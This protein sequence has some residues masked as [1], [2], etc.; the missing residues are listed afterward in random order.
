MRKT[1]LLL[2]LWVCSMTA[3]AQKG[4]CGVNAKWVLDEN[5]TLTINGEGEMYD[6]SPHEASWDLY[7]ERIK[8]VVVNGVSNVGSNAF[9]EYPNIVSVTLGEGLK[10]IGDNAFQG[11]KSLENL[12]VPETVE[13]YGL[14]AFGDC[15]SLKEVTISESVNHIG[16][17]AFENTGVEKVYWNAVECAVDV[18]N[19]NNYSPFW[20]YENRTLTEVH[21]GEKV[22]SVPYYLFYDCS[23]LTTVTTCGTI[24][25]VG[26][27]AFDGTYWFDSQ[28]ANQMVYIDH[29]AYKYKD[30][31]DATHNEP[32][33]LDMPEGTTCI[34]SG[35]IADNKKLVKV[36]IPT[37]MRYLGNGAFGGCTALGEVVYNAIEAEIMNGGAYGGF[38]NS[39]WSIT[40]GDRVKRIPKHLLWE[41]EGLE[42]I[43]LPESLESIGEYAFHG[44]NTVKE[45]VIPNNVNTIEYGAI[46][47]M[48]SLEKVTIGE[49]LVNLCDYSIFSE[50]PNLHQLV[51]NAVELDQQN[52]YY[53][54]SVCKAP[55]ETLLL[56]DKVKKVP[57][58]FLNGCTTLQSV[59]FGKSVETIGARAFYNCGG[60]TEVELPGS[61]KTIEDNAFYDTNIEHFFIPQSV[62]MLGGQSLYS[63]NGKCIIITSSNIEGEGVYLCKDDVVIYVPDIKSYKSIIHSF[64]NVQPMLT[65]TPSEFVYNGTTPTVSFACNMPGYEIASLG[66]T[67]MEKNAGEHQCKFSVSFTGERDFTVD[68]V[69]SYII[70]KGKQEIIWEQAL[71][72][73]HADDKV[74]LTATASSGLDVDYYCYD[75]GVEI[76]KEDGKTYLV[77]SYEGEITVYAQQEGDDNWEAIEEPVARKITIQPATSVT[78]VIRDDADIVTTYTID[79]R[80]ASASQKGLRIIHHS[81][82]RISKRIIQ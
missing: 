34:T 28:Y 80:K 69:Y 59:T 2:S 30:L 20:K 58:Q 76:T 11:C 78:G 29:V 52:I 19:G 46:S 6:Y 22:K 35:A 62:E 39:L 13:S 75:Y 66:E 1:L 63:K 68:Y 24:E 47:N 54:Y 43:V 79:G 38:P 60:L 55:L 82:G 23:T 70:N 64:S 53:D 10:N 57:I 12:S 45:L 72:D 71:D 61:L 48:A 44:C 51:W 65:A 40:F 18:N 42:E 26:E 8:S 31:D 49:G 25:Y 32:I 41:C 14:R 37:T 5:G 21:F 77:G 17:L 27:K 7:K 9:L 3:F 16:V 50:C 74:E 15:I 73:V 67:L 81:D 56:G 36:V 4:T 33:T